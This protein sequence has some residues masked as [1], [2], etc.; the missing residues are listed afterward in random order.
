MLQMGYL[1]PTH[2]MESLLNLNSLRLWGQDQGRRQRF[3]A[4]EKQAGTQRDFQKHGSQRRGGSLSGAAPELHQH[5]TNT[6]LPRC[7]TAPSGVTRS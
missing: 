4:L 3:K 7:V 6:A 1:G 5:P 2:T